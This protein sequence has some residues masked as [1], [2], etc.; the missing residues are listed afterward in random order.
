MAIA[1]VLS[2]I[3]NYFFVHTKRIEDCF[4]HCQE[5]KFLESF[6]AVTSKLAISLSLTLFLLIPVLIVFS[7]LISIG[8]EAVESK[9]AI[10]GGM[11]LT[12]IFLSGP[13]G[14]IVALRVGEKFKEKSEGASQE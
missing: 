1:A 2:L 14:M 10:G 12:L 4:S 8:G 7:K 5:I 13:I 9:L 3:F 11:F 6:A